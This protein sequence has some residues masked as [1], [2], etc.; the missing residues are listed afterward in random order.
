MRDL[1]AGAV[2][3]VGLAHRLD[4]IQREPHRAVAYRMQLDGR[5]LPIERRQLFGQHRQRIERRAAKVVPMG[6]AGRVRL[7]HG[8]GVAHRH[9]VEE[10]LDEVR[11]QAVAAHLRERLPVGQAVSA[12][13]GLHA[14]RRHHAQR[15]ALAVR[16]GGVPAGEDL[17]RDE[18]CLQHCLQEK[19][20]LE[21]VLE[22][23]AALPD[24]VDKPKRVLVS[25][26]PEIF[27]SGGATRLR[28]ASPSTDRA[29][30]NMPVGISVGIYCLSAQ[31]DRFRP[32]GMN[33][34]RA[35]ASPV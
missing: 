27:A 2:H 23:T 3:A 20:V 19:C 29:Y 14:H 28:M 21:I 12:G 6:I 11:T 25:K 8:R 16:V 15:Q 26:S 24:K 5:A 35:P 30:A 4:R 1:V 13:F 34:V 10:D 31:E 18:A 22:T 9:A 32:R 7:Q 17:A 33:S